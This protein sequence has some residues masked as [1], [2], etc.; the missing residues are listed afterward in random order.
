MVGAGPVV[1]AVAGFVVPAADETSCAA[2]VAV[3][4][5]NYVAVIR[6]LLDVVEKSFPVEAGAIDDYWAV[7]AMGILDIVAEVAVDSSVVEEPLEAEYRVERA[8]FGRKQSEVAS[9]QS[10]GR[11][12]A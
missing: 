11:D 5:M 2:G 3:V 7:A 10:K 6:V 9:S 1:D 4:E 8:Y 12:F